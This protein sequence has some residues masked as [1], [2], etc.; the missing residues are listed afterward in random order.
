VESCIRPDRT[1]S[2]DACPNRFY[3]YGVIARLALVAAAREIQ[4]A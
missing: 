2:P 1:R 4:S 3:A